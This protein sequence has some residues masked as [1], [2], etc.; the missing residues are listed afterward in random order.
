M[1][2]IEQQRE[3]VRQSLR[4]RR[5]RLKLLGICVDCGQ[6]KARLKSKTQRVPTLCAEC[7][8]DHTG[9]AAQARKDRHIAIPAKKPPVTEVDR[10]ERMMYL[11]AGSG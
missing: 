2:P 6:A 5:V 1:S 7:A 9:R 3:R 11:A 8:E 4:K 10:I